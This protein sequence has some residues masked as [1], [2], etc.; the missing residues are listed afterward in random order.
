MTH[1]VSKWMLIVGA[2]FG[3]I[4]VLSGSMGAHMLKAQL[5]A[6]KGAANFDL[7]STYLFYHAGALILTALLM[8]RF[9]RRGFQIAGGLFVFGSLLF[10]GSLFIYS[11]TADRSVTMFAPIGGSSLI[12][13]WITLVVTCVRLPVGKPAKTAEPSS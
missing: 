1:A 7:A 12:L 8:E 4:G 2:V 3:V 9:S 6:T 11:L 5:E 13:G 10:G